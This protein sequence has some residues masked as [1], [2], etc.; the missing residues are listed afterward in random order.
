VR[1]HGRL[2]KVF[3]AKGCC[4]EADFSVHVRYLLALLNF[5]TPSPAGSSEF[6]RIPAMPSRSDAGK[7]KG[8]RGLFLA[9]FLKIALDN[10]TLL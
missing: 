9:A 1:L 3:R 7:T 2:R 8:R 4:P 6:G 5:N 10:A